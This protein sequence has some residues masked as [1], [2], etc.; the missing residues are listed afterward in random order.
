MDKRPTTRLPARS[1]L[2]TASSSIPAPPTTSSAASKRSAST[3]QLDAEIEHALSRR[4]EKVEAFSATMTRNSLER[5]VAEAEQ[6]KRSVEAELLKLKQ[7]K[8]KAQRA[9]DVPIGVMQELATLRIEHANLVGQHQALASTLATKED[10]LRRSV[11]SLGTAKD[12][13]NNLKFR[14]QLAEAAA[15]RSENKAKIAQQEV[16]SLNSLLEK[17]TGQ[18]VNEEHDE[19]DEVTQRTNMR[20]EALETL[21]D[22]LKAANDVLTREMNELGGDTAEILK[23]SGEISITALKQALLQEKDL[24][25]SARKELDA[26]QKQVQDL[27]KQVDK[28]DDDLYRLRCDIGTGRHVPSGVRVLEMVDNPA[29][30]WFG[31]RE[32]D[33][34]RLK[35]ENEALRAMVGEDASNPM[36]TPTS[37][38][39]HVPKETLD[40]LRQEK[41]ELEVTIK[42]KEKRLLRLQQ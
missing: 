23:G 5:R 4:K 40:V 28:L 17:F 6:A 24:H 26:A 11:K 31:K 2:P 29:A 16:E 8:E 34:Q 22:E 21:V 32:E 25:S 19:L 33:V 15:T 7:E 37:N 35:K 20:I 10:E 9:S 42:E 18:E 39:G 30:R 14:L 36:V 27:K 13:F 3:A 12:E 1:R 38:N 41:E